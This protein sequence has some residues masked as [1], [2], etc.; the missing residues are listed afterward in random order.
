MSELHNTLGLQADAGL[1]DIRDAYKRLALRFHPDKCGGDSTKFCEVK[2]AYE[3]LSDQARRAQY[4]SL[5]HDKRNAL[6][7]ALMEALRSSAVRSTLSDLTQTFL[8]S[9][10]PS[11]AAN[12]AKDC[13]TLS[14]MDVSDGLD[15]MD[16]HATLDVSLDDVFNNRIKEVCVTR[17]LIGGDTSGAASIETRTYQVPLYNTCVQIQGAGHKH[18]VTGRAGDAHITIRCKRHRNIQRK[19]HDLLLHDTVSLFHIISGFIKVFDLFG[20]EVSVSSSAPLKEYSFDGDNL[21]I[22]IP[23]KGL[24][25]NLDG[26]RGN[27]FIVLNLVKDAHFYA[28][29]RKHFP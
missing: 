21:R 1:A 14:S 27:L 6:R 19:G 15:P 24:P 8:R 23:G 12:A 5:A 13:Y 18:A 26:D 25:E 28:R 4:L 16:I 2:L 11:P 29:L 22:C 9:V 10:H 3:I 20:Q 17:K 7:D